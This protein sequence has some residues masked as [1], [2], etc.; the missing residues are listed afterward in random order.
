MVAKI[1]TGNSLYGALSYNQSKID[2]GEAKVI[3][4]NKMY[5][6]LDEDLTIKNCFES[7]ALLMPERY[8]TEKPI[9]HISLN[10]H[11]DDKIEDWKYAEIAKEYMDKMGYGDQPYIIYKHEDID[12][13]HLHIITTN[14]DVN[15]KK[16]DSNNNFY[17]SKKATREIEQKYGLHTAERKSR[18]ERQTFDFRKVD[19][20][21]NDVKNQIRNVIKPIAASY[22]FQSFGEYRTLLSRY[23]ICVEESKGERNGRAYEGLIYYATNDKGDKVS[24]P[25]KSSLYGKAVGYEAI[26]SKCSQH[27]QTIKDRR[28]NKQTAERIDRA[29]LGV[30]N[31][32]E[33]KERLR[34]QNIDV[35][36]RENESGIIYGTT[37][38]DHNNQCVFNG[39][40][41]GG[42]FSANAINDRFSMPIEDQ[43]SQQSQGAEQQQWQE[44]HNDEFSLGGLF[45]LPIDEGIDDPEEESFRK[46]MQRKKKKGRKL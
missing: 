3:L 36:F 16:L 30:N 9:L 2:A 13:H 22:K 4:T 27:K 5:G 11:P 33:F 39:S 1:A 23:N 21:K 26:H 38:I 20:T 40:R 44:S 8:R 25:F 42:D 35:V 46:A 32:D 31:R 34:E 18:E 43:P 6:G 17:R 12:R 28:L 7:F 14:I 41:L 24:N 15:G 10:P 29:T 19:A 37:F 45:D